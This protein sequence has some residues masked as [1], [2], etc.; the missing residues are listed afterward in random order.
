MTSHAGDRTGPTELDPA[1]MPRL[2]DGP[3]GGPAAGHL[4][5]ADGPVPQDGPAPHTI[6]PAPGPGLRERVLHQYWAVC[7]AVT[8]MLTA[9]VALVVAGVAIGGFFSLPGLGVGLLL[10][11][12]ALWGAWLLAGLERHRVA[13]F[14][15]VDIG[16]RPD[17]TAPTWRRVLGLDEQRLRAL[18]WVGIHGLWGLF[19]GAVTLFLLARGLLLATLPLW[20]WAT[21]GVSLVGP[22]RV[23]GMV[24]MTMA[25]LLGVVVLVCLPWVARGLSSVDVALARWLIGTDAQAQLRA[26]SDR[27]DTL[28]T[29]REGTLDSVEAERRRIERDLHDGPQQRLVSIAMSLGLARDAL[30]RDPDD[31]AAARTVRGLLDEAHASSKEAIIE[32]RQVA[33]GIVPPILTDRGLDAAVSALAVRSPVPVSVS[34]RLPGTRLDPT[35]EAIAYF[36]VSEALTNVAKHAG[37][38]RATVELARANS[39]TGELLAITVTDDGQGGAVVGGGSGLT[40][41]QQRVAA[42][43][44]HL[45]VHSPVGSGTTVAITLPLRERIGS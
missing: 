39:L 40:G 35:V 32:M 10:L 3:W 5:R 16:R 26:M 43:D 12:P 21:D 6:P 2:G 42:V 24:G 25:W 18:G 17:S 31:P 14:L 29:T 8:S 22:V 34:S 44:G 20:G 30:D 37:A 28:T 15:G 45:H 11:S 7:Y 19:C 33:R 41:L 1:H 23:T 4:L 9:V 13:A 27:V 36:S 38:T